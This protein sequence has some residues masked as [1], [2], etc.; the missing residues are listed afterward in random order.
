MR[1]IIT[2]TDGVLE[3]ILRIALIFLVCAMVLMTFWQVL[4]RYVLLISVAYAEEL[5]RLAIVWCIYL[6]AALGV[7]HG[8]HM[9]VTALTD[10][11]PRWMQLA[12]RVFAYLLILLFGGI[13]FYFGIRH[14]HS[15][16]ND[17]TTSLG[18]H[19]YWFFI[20]N[21]I[22]G[23]LIFVYALANM[24]RCVMDYRHPDKEE[25]PKK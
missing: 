24:I 8:E 1:R 5:A 23:G 20:P 7:R 12:L 10:I 3:K 19:R 6:G 2:I 13:L 15:M 17:F 16:A 18:Y 25:A 9:Y 22:G 4:C 21:I 14:V 11:M